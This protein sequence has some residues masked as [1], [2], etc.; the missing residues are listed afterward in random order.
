V[1]ASRPIVLLVQPERDDREMY[2]E[3]LRHYG[4]AAVC[5]STA[6]DAL[7]LAPKADVIV[8][9]ILLPGQMDGIEFITRLRRNDATKRLPILVLTAAAWNTERERAEHAG[10]DAFLSKPC[11]PDAL[12]REVRRLLATTKVRDVRPTSI[13]ANL[14]ERPRRQTRHHRK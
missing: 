2:T 11:L 9:A 10:C 4:L 12:L 7:T 3:F 1:V 8:T 6:A 14:P 13:K 5:C